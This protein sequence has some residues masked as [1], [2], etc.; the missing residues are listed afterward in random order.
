MGAF[1][2]DLNPE[3]HSDEYRFHADSIALEHSRA[4]MDNSCRRSK[5]DW[6]LEA[7]RLGY[8]VFPL[9][10]HP[11]IWEQAATDSPKKI[12]SWWK[13]GGIGEGCNIAAALRPSEITIVELI[14]PAGRKGIEL[15]RDV[16]AD[17]PTTRTVITPRGIHI[18]LRGVTASSLQLPFQGVSIKSAGDFALL[19]G[20]QE[21]IDAHH[22]RLAPYYW[23]S[24]GPIS[25]V[26]QQLLAEMAKDEHA[27]MAT[28]LPKR[29]TR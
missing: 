21:Y 4:L 16:V 1:Y 10:R 26:P 24:L 28:R 19:P 15:L 8:K 25:S 22:S 17:L 5:L 2:E 27:G 18:H 20:S 14:F 11:I 23:K 12:S 7:A 13:F 9:G 29:A 6:A 3:R